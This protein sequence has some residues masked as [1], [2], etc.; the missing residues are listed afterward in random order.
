M[1]WSASPVCRSVDNEKT[2]TDYA[3]LFFFPSLYSSFHLLLKLL[4]SFSF[5]L[6]CLTITTFC[7]CYVCA[8]SK[9]GVWLRYVCRRR[10]SGQSVGLCTARARRQEDR[11][12]SCIPST[13]SSKGTVH[14][15]P[16]QKVLNPWT[17]L[18]NPLFIY[19]HSRTHSDGD[20]DEEDLCWRTVC[21]VDGRRRQRLLWT[22]WTGRKSNL[23]FL[24][25]SCVVCG[26]APCWWQ[27]SYS[28]FVYRTVRT[29]LERHV[30][31]CAAVAGGQ[32]LAP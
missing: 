24:L 26:P 23:T 13:S 2:P 25:L 20:P 19:T 27:R 5:S 12:Q 28:S 3:S 17:L 29:S 4:F 18:F 21:S 16:T 31:A 9:K 1:Y 15:V 32:T 6:Y 10:I 11:P 8:A 30:I 7:T 22:I 14:L